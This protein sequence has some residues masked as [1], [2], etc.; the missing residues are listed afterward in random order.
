MI[1][2]RLKFKNP[3]DSTMK[4]WKIEPDGTTVVTFTNVKT[5]ETED[6]QNNK[7]KRKK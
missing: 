7:E 4:S 5:I 2:V 3:Q 1:Q 6:I